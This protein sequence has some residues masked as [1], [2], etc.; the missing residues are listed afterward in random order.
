MFKFLIISILLS[1]C[2]SSGQYL[3]ENKEGWFNS[4]DGLYYCVAKPG[5]FPVC[6]QAKRISPRWDGINDDL[7]PPKKTS[8]W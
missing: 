5:D 1:S 8:G 6:H 2:A 4:G 7:L 3:T